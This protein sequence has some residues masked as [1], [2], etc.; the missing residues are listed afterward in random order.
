MFRRRAAIEPVIGHLEKQ[1]RM[2][3]NYYGGNNATKINALLAC[4]A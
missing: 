3:Q 2:A 4:A 1:F